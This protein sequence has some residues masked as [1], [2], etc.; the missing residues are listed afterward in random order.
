MEGP[1]MLMKA[2]YIFIVIPIKIAMTFFTETEKPI[3]KFIWK[4]K[5]L[6]IVKAIQREKRNTGGIKIYNFKLYY[7]TIAIKTLWNCHKNRHE[8][9]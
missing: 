2:I 6:Q 3:L 8:D 9:Q 5:W 4:H 1:S 7:R